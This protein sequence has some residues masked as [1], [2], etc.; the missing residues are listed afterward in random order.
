M[1]MRWS[2]GSAPSENFHCGDPGEVSHCEIFQED[3]IFWLA[4]AGGSR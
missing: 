1:V 3:L 4:T 2:T